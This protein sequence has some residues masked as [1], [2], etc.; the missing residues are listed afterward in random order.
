MKG[1]SFAL[2]PPSKEELDKW[3][4][5]FEE[6]GF[7]HSAAIQARSWRARIMRVVNGRRMYDPG[8]NPAAGASS[9][10]AAF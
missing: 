8:C 9:L 5:G 7:F 6:G 4:G 2:G 10:R 1:M 3:A